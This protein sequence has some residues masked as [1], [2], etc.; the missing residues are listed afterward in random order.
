[1]YFYKKLYVSDKIRHPSLVKWKLRHQAGQLTVYVLILCE[2]G[3]DNQLELM[4]SAFLQQ[5]FYRKNPP[6][7]IGLAAGQ[8]DGIELIR[9]IVQEVYDHTGTTDVRAYLFPH[10]VRR[11]NREDGSNLEE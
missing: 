10:G 1:M 6:Y 8:S 9:R 7:I 3:M 4:H 2:D 11:G 5:P